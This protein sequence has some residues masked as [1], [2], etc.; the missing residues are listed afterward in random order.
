MDG[1]AGM[2]AVT[3]GPGTCGHMLVEDSKWWA[4]LSEAV[5]QNGALLPCP[6]QRGLGLRAVVPLVK[7]SVLC[8][9][10]AEK[11]HTQEFMFLQSQGT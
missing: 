8:E 4:G 3:P 2:W 5:S 10:W 11:F 1:K 9:N 7:K 6:L